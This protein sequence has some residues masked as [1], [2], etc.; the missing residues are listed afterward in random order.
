[1][2]VGQESWEV[3][4]GTRGAKGRGRRRVQ[5]EAVAGVRPR[6]S[7]KFAND[8]ISAPSACLCVT[9]C[10]GQPCEVSR[11]PACQLAKTASKHD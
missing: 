8:A 3:E 5:S 6:P 1:M 2:S 10:M 7:S 11:C 9:M 4:S